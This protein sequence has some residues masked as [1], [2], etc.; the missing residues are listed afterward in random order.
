MQKKLIAVAV[1]GALGAPAAA[2]AQAGT[3]Q[4]F[5]TL[6]LEYGYVDQGTGT[7]GARNNVDI[8]QTPNSEIGFKGEE[9]LGGGISAW[10]Q[11]AST[12]DLRGQ[13]PEGFCSRNSAIGLKGS[14]GNIFMGRWDTPFKRTLGPNRVGSNSTGL[15]GAAFLLSGGST[16]TVNASSRAAF[17]RRQSNSV[18]YESPTFS[19]FQV[20]G[21]FSS[22][23]GATATTTAQTGAKPRVYSLAAQYRNGP[24]YIS[25][26]Y[27]RHNEFAGTAGGGDDK[28]WHIGANYTFMGKVKVGGVFTEQKFSTSAATEGKV[29]AWTVGVDWSIQGP[30]GLRASYTK[31]DDV[32]GTSTVTV[33]GS[34]STRP[35]AGPDT[36]ADL[37]TI[38]YVHGF[39][40]RTELTLGY[41]KL[42]ND[43]AASYTLGGLSGSAAGNNQDA[44]GLGLKHRF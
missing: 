16:S 37:W 39:S 24:I 23:N 21:A 42:D 28:G 25:G 5:G 27:E 26:A 8:M 36:S 29:K 17:Q 31:A 10:F 44:W 14:F 34:G 38:Q 22:T 30:H 32:T 40:K 33:A 4:V 20:M 11:C 43:A 18:N 41:A 3:V 35:A 13:S 9:K 7:N 15:W 19:G 1:A 12:A 6:Y 2:L